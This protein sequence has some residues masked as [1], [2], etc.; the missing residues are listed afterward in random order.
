MVKYEQPP[1]NLLEIAQPRQIRPLN[2]YVMSLSELAASDIPPRE[3]LLGEWFPKESIGM[4]FA[5][6]G[7]GKSWF[8]MT[9]AI[10]ISERMEAFLGWPLKDHG[11]VLYVDG[12]MALADLK[13]RFDELSRASANNSDLL[14]LPAERLYRESYPISLDDE[15]EQV[16]INDMLKQL[17]YEGKRPK[18]IILDNLSSL[19]RSVNENDNS[20]MEAL[21]TWLNQLRHQGYAVLVVHHA[22]KQGTQRGASKTEDIMD[23]VIKLEEPKVGSK[24]GR[25]ELTFEKVRAR[26][27]HPDEISCKL[28]KGLSGQLFLA[29][30]LS[31]NSADMEMNT[32]RVIAEYKGSRT[33]SQRMVADKIQKSTSAVSRYI[34]D[35][36]TMGYLH[37]GEVLSLTEYGRL[38]VHE[39][40]PNDFPCPEG[41]HVGMRPA[42]DY[43]F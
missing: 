5:K 38:V 8:C 15:L 17:E 39:T 10:A 20:E 25:F 4:V 29:H 9:L 34:R 31:G 11:P 24:E 14:I 23:F 2:P 19:R 27:P 30:G 42:D 37:E 36:K 28:E 7:V 33:I 40:W 22:G 41:M 26:R 6:R 32:L 35:L 43:P 18:L 16:A 12:E 21:M 1:Q 13:G 3:F